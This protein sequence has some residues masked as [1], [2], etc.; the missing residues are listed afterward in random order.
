MTGSQPPDLTPLTLLEVRAT[1]DLDTALEPRRNPLAADGST[2]V[3]PTAS[4]ILKF[5][6][7]LSPSTATRQSVCIH[8]AL[9]ASIR[10]SSECQ[11]L[12]A[13]TRLLL[14]PTYNPVE[15][16]VIYRQR[17]DQPPLAPGQ[18]YRLIAFRPSDEDASGFRAF[19]DAP[20]QATRQF[21][22]SVLPESPPGATQERLPQS[23]FYCRRD[24]ACL[25][26]CTDDACRQQCTLWGSGVEPYLRRCSSGAGCHASPDTAGSGLSLLNSDLI[27]RT[28]I[29][30]TAHQTQTGEHA[31]EPE[32]SP[33]RFGRAMPIIDPQNPGNSYLLYKLLI[34]PNAIDHTLDPDDAM[35]LEGELARLHTSVVV[36]LPM[37]PQ[38]TPSFWLH[39]PNLPDVDPA[40]IVPR[41]DGGDIDIITAWIILGAPI[42]DCA[43][44]PYE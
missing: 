25:A 10:T 41:V 34:G 40:S 35:Q 14:E 38:R 20:L 29:G 26:Q 27:Q 22:F 28:A 13:A 3:L 12:P 15:R 23:D 39:D 19:D 4:F 37:P 6:R 24:P 7:F 30:K 9:T 43:E 18:K 31:D 36:G 44:P 5:D 21:D 16:E 1:T 33:R 11:Q 17:P 32:F 8:S 2:R 42:R